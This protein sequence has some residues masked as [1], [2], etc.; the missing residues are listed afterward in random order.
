MLI[1]VDGREM[2]SNRTQRMIEQPSVVSR[3]RV[4]EKYTP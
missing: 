4:A 2:V 3:L 1:L